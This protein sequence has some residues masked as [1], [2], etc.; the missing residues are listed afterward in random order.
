MSEPDTESAAYP[1]LRSRLLRHV[2]LPLGLVW[3]A[4]SVVVIS[5][6]SHF[7]QAAYDRSLLDDAYS[8]AN[9]VRANEAGLELMLSTRE[10]RAVLFDQVES[11]YFAVRRADGSL[12]TGQA[13]LFMPDEPAE[14]DAPPFRFAN[15]SFQG[16][17]LRAVRL[18]RSDPQAFEVVMAQT[19]QSRSALLRSLLLYSV[20]PE[21][22]LLVILAAWLSRAIRRDLQPLTSLQQAMEQRDAQDL[23]PLPV[24]ANT[25]DVHRL[26]TALNGLLIRVARGVQAQREFAGNVA[27]ELRTPLAGIRALAEYGLAQK[28]PEAWRDQ[29]Q[30]IVGSEARASHLVDQLLA[31]ALA[32]EARTQM[33]A[34]PVALDAL[35]RD[36]VLRLLSRAD[37]AGVDLGAQ[38]LDEPVTVL[39]QATLLEGIL[40]NLLD[41]ALRYGVPTAGQPRSI[42]V[43]LRV[44]GDGVQLWVLDNGPGIAPLERERILQRWVRGEEREWMGEGAGLGMA[45][46]SRYAQ[47]MG[48]RF[49]LGSGPLGVGLRAG[50]VLPADKV[51]RAPALAA[52]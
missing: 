17:P 24:V 36:A 34:V 46:V 40:N 1:S 8:V 12:L 7:T 51:V 4:G 3:L 45:I 43:E 32:D 33:Q 21:V 2:L 50:I 26:A 15:I 31:L 14:P 47:L 42:T 13:G 16:K 19:T 35:V 22:L 44:D 11:V 39:A 52:T 10:V 6:A 18:Q 5:V 37:A 28:E 38:G 20:I 27:H 30:R 48:A 29:L 23:T 41:N 25:R 49:E 9:N